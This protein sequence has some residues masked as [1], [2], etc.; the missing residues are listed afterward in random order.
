[1]PKYW[2][3]PRCSPHDYNCMRATSTR[4]TT[5]GD[6]TTSAHGDQPKPTHTSAVAADAGASRTLRIR[7]MILPLHA[8]TACLG[9]FA[10]LCRWAAG[11]MNQVWALAGGHVTCKRHDIWRRQTRTNSVRLPNAHKARHDVQRTHCRLNS[12]AEQQPMPAVLLS[13]PTAYPDTRLCQALHIQQ[14][15]PSLAAAHVLQSHPRN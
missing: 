15:N 7:L 2:S 1:M 13:R 5:A 10:G 11:A 6:A 8:P 12:Q 3:S 4:R 9:L 14:S